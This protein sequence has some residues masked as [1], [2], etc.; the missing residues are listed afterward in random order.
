MLR[1]LKEEFAGISQFLKW[2]G[3]EAIII[4]SAALFITL[5][6][7][8]PVGRDYMSTFIY[9]GICPILVILLIMRKNPLDFGL[10]LGNP[11]VWGFYVVV[12]C[13]VATAILYG[14]S[15]IPAL[16]RYY[17]MDGLKLPVYVLTAVVSIAASEF[18]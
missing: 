5:D 10:K 3:R 8:H 13:V 4:V 15:F 6:R 9:Y 16:Q 11:K 12:I 14:S 1:F 2:Y 17:R 7:Y 18:M